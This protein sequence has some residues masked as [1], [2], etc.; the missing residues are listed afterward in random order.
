MRLGEQ[1]HSES[2]A[3]KSCPS[4]CWILFELDGSEVIFITF[5][6]PALWKPFM[7]SFLFS[8]FSFHPLCFPD[9]H[10]FVRL[11]FTGFS[12]PDDKLHFCW[13][14]WLSFY[15][16]YSCFFCFYFSS[17]YGSVFIWVCISSF[18]VLLTAERHQQVSWLGQF[19]WYN[20]YYQHP[21]FR[22]ISGSHTN[23]SIWCKSDTSSYD[24]W[25][26]SMAALNKAQIWRWCYMSDVVQQYK[27]K[28]RCIKPF[29]II[30]L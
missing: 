29:W 3:I 12:Q 6:S 7:L 11:V 26:L 13:V 9:T 17:A 8:L 20:C 5:I 23:L 10:G 14:C 24:I 30:C 1:L 4:C 22:R 2:V 15:L 25:A 21:T 19:G 28:P 27:V 16:D 18:Y